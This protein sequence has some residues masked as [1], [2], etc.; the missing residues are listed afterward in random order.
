MWCFDRIINYVEFDR[1]IG[2]ML[3]IDRRACRSK[4]HKK[5]NCTV[6]KGALRFCANYRHLTQPK[7]T[8]F[9][10]DS[11]MEELL[12]NP[13]IVSALQGMHLT[14]IEVAQP[15]KEDRLV[16]LQNFIVS[17]I[18]WVVLEWFFIKCL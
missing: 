12:A 3:D 4:V 5:D 10:Q 17:F 6:Q 14:D 1:C 11:V 18:A 15:A 7:V 2:R 16:T 8:L 13:E 9:L